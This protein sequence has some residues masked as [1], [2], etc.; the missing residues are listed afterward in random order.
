MMQSLID[1]RHAVTL[2]LA[3]QN[4]PHLFLTRNE[5]KDINNIIKLLKPFKLCGEKLF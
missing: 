2:V 5:N 4:K 1:S 3:D